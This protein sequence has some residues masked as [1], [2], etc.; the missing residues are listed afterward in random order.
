MTPVPTAC[1]L[2]EPAPELITS[3]NTPR[4]KA[5]EVITIGRRR[6]RQAC[7]VAAITSWPWSTAALANSMIRMAF[8][9][10]RPSMVRR[11]T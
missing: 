11:P 8:L 6:R 2:P 10:V 4:P 9:A 1:W 5:I 7:N 3:G